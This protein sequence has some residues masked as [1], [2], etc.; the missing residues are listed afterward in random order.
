[1]TFQ[2]LS[3]SGTLT[4]ATAR[5]RVTSFKRYHRDVHLLHAG[6]IGK[7]LLRNGIVTNTLTHDFF[8]SYPAWGATMACG[9]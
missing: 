6:Q 7:L 1:M 3:V 9:A 4:R 2:I 5:Y 8:C